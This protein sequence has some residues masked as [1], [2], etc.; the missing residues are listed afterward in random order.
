[1]NSLNF[2]KNTAKDKYN[3]F[4]L[5]Y[6]DYKKD[7]T[8]INK[9]ISLSITAWH[10][11]DWAFLDYK[12]FHKSNSLGAFREKLYPKCPSLKIMH[13]LANASKHK[14]LTRSKAELKNTE[15]HKGI[16]S[17][18][19]NKKFDTTYLLIE[20]RDGNKLRFN[21]EIDKVKVFWDSY[22]SAY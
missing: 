5:E 1:M 15:K 13:D 4:L 10:L 21:E 18:I 6:E 2:G 11:I 20:L 17:S 7:N 19:F 3:T 8:S 9:A 16:F 14:E 12:T 22:F